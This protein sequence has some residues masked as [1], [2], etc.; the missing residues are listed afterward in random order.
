M[1]PDSTDPLRALLNAAAVRERADEMLDAA[2]AGQVEGW[3]VDLDRLDDAAALTASVT[4]EA[5]PDLDI[6][7]HARW[8]H[9]VAGA[10][11]RPRGDPAERA[12][13]A[14]DLVILSVLLDA[15]AGPGWRWR[16]PETGA[17]LARS[18]GLAVASQRL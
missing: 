2:L 1:E 18:E 16:D 5:Y 13:A 6:P 15:G 17:V 10:P 8:R 12:R 3:S 4:R 9:F 7:F 11:K 14:F